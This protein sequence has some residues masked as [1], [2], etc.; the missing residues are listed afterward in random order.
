MRRFAELVD[1]L[2]YTRSRNAKLAA[3]AEYLRTTP[4]PER[5][6][7]LAALTDSLDFPAVKSATIRGVAA[8]RIDPEL[9]RLSRHHVG[10]TAET[11]ALIWPERAPA[12]RADPSIDALVAA[13]TAATRAT[14]PR[15][16][17]IKF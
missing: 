16:C 4:D 12:E 13:L 2:V 11:V 6:W 10:D 7:A 15:W 17:S 5:G 14:T 8:T 3:I 1:T 9:L